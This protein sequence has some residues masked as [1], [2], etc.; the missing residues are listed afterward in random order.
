MGDEQHRA[1]HNSG[2]DR[3]EGDRT[4]SGD[5]NVIGIQDS[6]KRTA[7]TAGLDKGGEDMPRSE[8]VR[9]IGSVPGPLSL[10]TAAKVI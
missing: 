10:Y 8:K 6:S 2:R 5:K 7:G 4:A 9:C 1:G 3:R